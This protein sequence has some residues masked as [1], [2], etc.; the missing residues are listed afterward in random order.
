MTVSIFLLEDILSDLNLKDRG[1][2]TVYR[3]DCGWIFFLEDILSDLYL[4]DS[5]KMIV[6][7]G[8]H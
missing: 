2:M 6:T 4:K 1:K 7:M 8:E 5:G 3:R